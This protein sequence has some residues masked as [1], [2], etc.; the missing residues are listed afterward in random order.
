[1]TRTERVA[2]FPDE[3]ETDI[4]YNIVM[5]KEPLTA[6]GGQS[7]EYAQVFWNIQIVDVVGQ[8]ERAV[9]IV[10]VADAEVAEIVAANLVEHNEPESVPVYALIVAALSLV[11]FARLGPAVRLLPHVRAT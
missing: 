11:A 8:T 4:K 3:E 6:R 9:L 10:R 5:P 7:V 1:M 2:L